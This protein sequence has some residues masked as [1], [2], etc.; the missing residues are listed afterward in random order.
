LVRGFDDRRWH[1]L[2]NAHPAEPST[3]I[4]GGTA[5]KKLRIGGDLAFLKRAVQEEVQSLGI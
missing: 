2:V 4:K 5:V 3:Y 1:Y